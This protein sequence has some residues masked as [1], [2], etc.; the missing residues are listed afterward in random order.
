MDQQCRECGI[1]N[2]F[3]LKR[4]I[5]ILIKYDKWLYNENNKN[6]NCFSN[7]LNNDSYQIK[8][9]LNDYQHIKDKQ[10]YLPKNIKCNKISF[11]RISSQRHR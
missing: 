10:Y 6:N 7:I 4:I 3:S 2:C 11:K 9:I 8:Y 1:Y 5:E